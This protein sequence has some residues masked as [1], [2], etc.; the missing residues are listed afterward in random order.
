MPGPL[1]AFSEPPTAAL[2]IMG[3]MTGPDWALRGG[4]KLLGEQPQPLTQQNRGRM[5]R[6]TP[7]QMEPLIN[8]AEWWRSLQ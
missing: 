5:E 3:K 6:P 8:E 4:Q 7:K 2:A 1:K